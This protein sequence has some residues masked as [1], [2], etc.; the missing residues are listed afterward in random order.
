MQHFALVYSRAR[1]GINAPLIAIEVDLSNG[2]PG[3]SIVGLPEASVRESRDRVRSALLN[4]GFEFPARRITVNLAPADIP[5]EG[6]RFDLPI[7][8]GILAASGQVRC[9]DLSPWEFVGEL[10]LT[11]EVRRIDASL[12][13]AIQCENTG[14][15]LVLPKSNA[16]EIFEFAPNTLIPVQSLSETVA[17][18]QGQQPLT[19]TPDL[20]A[21][22]R[23]L[24]CDQQPDFS[25][26]TGQ[27]A[28]RRALEIAA[29]GNHNLLFSGP[30][31][32]G[33]TLMASRLPSILPPLNREELLETSSIYSVSG[34]SFHYHQQRPFRAPHHTASA[35]ALV[36]GGSQARPGEVSLAHG[37]VLF[38]DELPEYPRKVL[39]VLREPLEAGEITI[40][41]ANMKV[42]YPARF[43]LIAAMNP[44]PCGYHKD[45]LHECRCTPDQVVRYRN[46][47][48]GPLL[49]RIDLFVHVP[50]LPPG[51]LQQTQD[52][53]KSASIR[54]RVLAAREQ[55]QQRSGCCNA[56]LSVSALRDHCSL[57]AACSDLL[58]KAEARLGLSPRAQHRI[59]KVSR[60]IADLDHSERIQFK[61]LSEALTYRQLPA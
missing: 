56:L 15:K 51:S 13:A 37:G 57:D 59:V 33:K 52:N 4:A 47:V 45:P 22:S 2:L 38:L 16:I 46:R 23:D 61:H 26:I 42:R 18:L 8:I 39:D 49:D 54:Q 6:S 55:Q 35:V 5:K 60:T 32:T 25:D 1:I 44:C 7:A 48:S 40:A 19:V 9:Q 30:P 50:R 11:S 58:V 24:D 29:A 14:R 27:H 20:A 12:P 34:D 31:G 17:Y 53:E 41:R 36:G 21:P 28:A 43:Q 3:F 10:G